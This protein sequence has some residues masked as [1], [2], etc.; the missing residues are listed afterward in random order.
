MG[1]NLSH[2]CVAKMTVLLHDAFRGRGEINVYEHTYAAQR[3]LFLVYLKREL[4]LKTPNWSTRG[5]LKWI[6][7]KPMGVKYLYWLD[8]R[9]AR[10][11]QFTY[12]PLS[13]FKVGCWSHLEKCE[14]GITYSSRHWGCI[15]LLFASDK[16]YVSTKFTKFSVEAKRPSSRL[17]E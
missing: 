6:G 17:L 9:Y 7:S 12:D 13:S 8:K 2:P 5:H 4:N 11:Q 14:L 15:R 1:Y 10:I 16:P 3:F